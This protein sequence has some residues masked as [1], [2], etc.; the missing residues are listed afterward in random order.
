MWRG[1]GPQSRYVF[2]TKEWFSPFAH[3]VGIITVSP[4]CELFMIR[5]RH[6]SVYDILRLYSHIPCR[7]RSTCFRHAFVVGNS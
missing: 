6:S 5:V 2:M 7:H 3:T 4:V 1:I